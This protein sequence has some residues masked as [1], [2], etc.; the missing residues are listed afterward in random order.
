[1]NTPMAELASIFA[2][3]EEKLITQKTLLRVV[4]IRANGPE[5]LV[6][7]FASY[8]PLQFREADIRLMCYPD[9]TFLSTFLAAEHQF[10]F[11]IHAINC[12][13]KEVL[14]TWLYGYEALMNKRVLLNIRE[15]CTYFRR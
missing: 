3:I 4:Y 2:K 6:E 5:T 1:M 8:S 14:V 15:S 7:T 9:E 13:W 12:E 11:R 10:V